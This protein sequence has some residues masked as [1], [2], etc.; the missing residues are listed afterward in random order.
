MPLPTT[1][2]GLWTRIW[3]LLKMNRSLVTREEVEGILGLP[4]TSTEMDDEKRVPRLGAQYLH[5]AR[6]ELPGLGLVDVAM[7]DDP[8]KI[9]LSIS[10]GPEESPTPNCLDLGQAIADVNKLGWAGGTRSRNP[11]RG[12]VLFHREEDLAEYRRTGKVPDV[13]TGSSQL[14]LLVPNQFSSCVN[15]VGA[16]IWRL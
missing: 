4:F 14:A 8:K 6:R 9:G 15:G 16:S 13:F 10:W 11:G 2:Q 12:S 3:T 5:T 1:P 7:F